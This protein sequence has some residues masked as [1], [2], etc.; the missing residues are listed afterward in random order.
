[1]DEYIYVRYEQLEHDPDNPRALYPKKDLDKMA[2]SIRA[3]GGVDQPLIVTPAGAMKDGRP[4]YY[5]VDG[6]FRLASTRMLGDDAPL[7]KCEVK[8]KLSR[9]EKLLIMWRTSEHFYPK[10]PI[11]RAKLFYQLHVI[12]GMTQLEIARRLG[13]SNVTV[14]NTLKLLELEKQIQDHIAQKRLPSDRRVVDALLSLQD[15][16]ERLEMAERFA[17][18]K[19]TIATIVK[20]CKRWNEQ[21]ESSSHNDRVDKLLEDGTRPSMAHAAATL[22]KD[23]LGGGEVKDWAQVRKSVKQACEACD[24]KQDVLENATEPAWSFVS[25]GA[26]DTCDLCP[27]KNVREICRGCPL[28]EF[29]V[30]LQQNILIKTGENNNGRKT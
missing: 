25:H 30:R 7:L 16:Q 18:S 24:L 11:D 9:I 17:Q 20:V 12:E 22:G 3:G 13:T 29:L 5:V 27:L 14:S 28:T 21:K 26:E 23:S 10:S 19:V 8:E 2:K 6:N 1:M 15:K 4:K